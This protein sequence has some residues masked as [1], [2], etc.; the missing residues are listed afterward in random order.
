LAQDEES[1]DAAALPSVEVM[2]CLEK[3]LLFVPSQHINE[4]LP[5]WG[6]EAGEYVEALVELRYT[7]N[8]D[9]TVG[10]IAVERIIGPS[11]FARHAISAVKGWTFKPAT[12]DG[13]PVAQSREI[14]FP[15]DLVN[16]SHGARDSVFSA[17]QKAV[18]E[19]EAG[20]LTDADTEL[21]AQQDKPELTFYE[22]GMMANLQGMIALKNKDYEAASDDVK[23]AT[24]FYAH[25]LPPAVAVQLYKTRIVSS[26]ARGDI[27]DAMGAT[28]RLQ[29]VQGFDPSDPIAKVV[30]DVRAKLDTT[31]SFTMSGKIPA[32]A[33]GDALVMYLYR[34]DFTFQN[35][36]GSLGKFDLNCK[37]ESVQSSVSDAAEW[38]VPPNWSQC[39]LLVRGTPGTTFDVVEYS[40][41]N[42]AASAPASSSPPQPASTTK[43]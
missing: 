35:I 4:P 34:R 14:V 7:V 28:R 24:D 6:R 43:Q 27:M 37:Q 38:H 39:F 20:D 26:L 16:V 12:L 2:P 31:P 1:G 32:S 30:S 11:D 19:I 15:F 5:T 23:V 3:C 13:K 8:P 29:K 9:G 41:A 22:R 33:N 17:Y 21:K 10:D 40:P 36:K 25:Q 42:S 18:K